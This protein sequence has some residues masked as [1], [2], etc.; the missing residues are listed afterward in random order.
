MAKRTRRERRLEGDKP[1]Q[2]TPKAAPAASLFVEEDSSV[3][4]T[5]EFTSAPA[6]IAQTAPVNNR[7][8]VN[9]AQEYFYVYSELTTILI[10]TALMFGVIM[11]LSFVI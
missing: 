10:I 6:K 8:V 3:M 4:T 5:E 11:G 9:F 7:K 1:K 2:F